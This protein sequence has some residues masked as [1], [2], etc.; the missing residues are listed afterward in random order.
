MTLRGDEVQKIQVSADS[1]EALDRVQR[2]IIMVVRAALDR[3]EALGYERGSRP[4]K[5]IEIDVADDGLPILVKLGREVVFS[6]QE[7]VDHRGRLTISGE[8]Q[9]DVQPRK[10]NLWRRIFRRK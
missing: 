4:G 8:W 3:L 2:S 9:K 6:V 5:G 7:K 10:P 1:P